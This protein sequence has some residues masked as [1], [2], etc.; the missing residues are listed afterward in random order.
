M[1]K[2]MK[3]KKP[4]HADGPWTHIYLATHTT[5]NGNVPQLTPCSIH[6]TR[7]A[8]VVRGGMSYWMVISQAAQRLFETGVVCRKLTNRPA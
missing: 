5:V 3:R 1:K 2:E 4:D 8:S 6:R 7:D